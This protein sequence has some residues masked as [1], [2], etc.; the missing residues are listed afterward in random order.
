M[1]TLEDAENIGDIV[2]API[3]R[4]FLEDVRDG[5][6]DGFPR[7]GLDLQQLENAV[8]RE[9][10]GLDDGSGGVLVTG[11]LHSSSANGR[12]NPGDV[13]LEIDHHPIL[14]NNTVDLGR[15]LLVDSRFIVQQ[16]QVGDQ[17][18]VKLRRAGRVHTVQIKLRAPDPL[19]ELA[20]GDRRPSYL[21][22]GGLVFQ[23]V[24]FRYLGEFDDI[25]PRLLAFWK[26]S[27]LSDRA[28]LGR[29]IAKTHRSEVV[30]L[31]GVLAS[32]LTRGYQ[33]F[34]GEVVYAVNGT[35]VKNLEHLAKLLDDPANELVEIAMQQGGR[36]ALRR[37]QVNSESAEILAR[38]QVSA[39]RS[40]DLVVPAKLAE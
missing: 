1:Q 34:E 30:A 31:T 32:D 39:D 33:S 9:Q 35:P 28:L 17:I 21:I 16:K 22:Y 11:V 5:H 23:P 14:Q 19:I 29:N 26:A 8:Q 38:Y 3:I 18:E 25:P 4:H 36:I 15:G 37:D 13:I 7:L 24:T 27:T 10:L 2:P 20:S 12:I 40:P 6:F